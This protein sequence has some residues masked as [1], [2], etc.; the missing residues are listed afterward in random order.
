[1]KYFIILQKKAQKQI[2]QTVF[3][4]FSILKIFVENF[5]E[6]ATILTSVG[7]YGAERG[8]RENLNH[9]VTERG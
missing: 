4:L 2:R 8:E 1:M 9:A 5:F 7:S 6:N 3:V